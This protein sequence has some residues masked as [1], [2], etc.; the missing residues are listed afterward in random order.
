MQTVSEEVSKVQETFESER[1]RR[2]VVLSHVRVEN[3]QLDAMRDKP[4]AIFKEGMVAR[5]VRA[6]TEIR[7]E[8]A[9]RVYAEQTFVASLESY[10]KSLQDGLR[11][12]NK[13]VDEQGG[14]MYGRTAP[15][16]D[17][18]LFHMDLHCKRPQQRSTYKS[19]P[20]PL[21]HV[22]CLST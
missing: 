18:R 6:T 10:T 1:G 9:K 12:V 20:L 19:A 3:D 14:A 4:D 21:P 15:Y 11:M 2:E 16:T 22:R 7:A 17:S 13:Q 5:M 8:T